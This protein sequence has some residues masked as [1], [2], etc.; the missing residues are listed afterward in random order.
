MIGRRTVIR[1]VAGFRAGPGMNEV[2]DDRHDHRLPFARPTG[3]HR[4]NAR[5]QGG[6][7]VGG[8]AESDSGPVTGFAVRTGNPG[9]AG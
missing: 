5:G 2:P 6:R 3:E 1:T 8:R 9:R 4:S 7:G